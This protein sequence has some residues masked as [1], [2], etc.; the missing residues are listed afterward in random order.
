[1]SLTC[2]YY[3]DPEPGDVV[4]YSSTDWTTHNKRLKQKCCS[5]GTI[6]S[7]NTKCIEFTRY[8]VSESEIE[9]RI[10]GECSDNGPRRA[11]EFMC[12]ECG[13]RYIALI[14]HRYAVSIYDDMRKLMIEH[15]ELASAGM[16]GCA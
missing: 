15:D 10:Y 4:W 11:S 8:K 3:Y 13:W 12:F 1:M 16:A 5:C 2:D 7:K 6:V 9:V 14:G